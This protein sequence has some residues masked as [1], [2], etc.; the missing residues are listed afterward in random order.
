MPPIAADF[1]DDRA[2]AIEEEG[3]GE[4]RK[5]VERRRPDDLLVRSGPVEDEVVGDESHTKPDA[6][7]DRIE[8]TVPIADPRVPCRGES[9]AMREPDPDEPRDSEGGDGQRREEP[10]TRV[11]LQASADEERRAAADGDGALH[12]CRQVIAGGAHVE[13]SRRGRRRRA[14]RLR[15][16]RTNDRRTLGVR[17]LQEVEPVRR[18]EIAGLATGSIGMAVLPDDP[19]SVDVDDHDPVPVV[20]VDRDQARTDA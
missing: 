6:P 10:D 14:R 5:R 11:P 17:R 15:E 4:W 13:P 2:T 16:Q 7:Q 1:D 19:A 20:V 12:R 9:R 18:V 3:A 8:E